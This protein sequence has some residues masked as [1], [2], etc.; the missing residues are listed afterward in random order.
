MNKIPDRPKESIPYKQI[1]A[2]RAHIKKCL[3]LGF[4]FEDLEKQGYNFYTPLKE[5]SK[6][7]LEAIRRKNY[8]YII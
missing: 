1:A 5:V 8:K 7:E 3:Q 2:D 6:E 4:T